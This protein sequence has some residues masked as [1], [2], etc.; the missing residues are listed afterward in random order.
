MLTTKKNTQPSFHTGG[1]S[2]PVLLT[3]IFPD[4]PKGLA[5]SF[6]LRVIYLFLAASGLCCW[7]WAFCSCCGCGGAT[8]DCSVQDS[9]YGSVLVS[10]HRL[11]GW[12]Q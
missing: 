8:L 3:V 7:V 9:H 1:K 4:L 10:D 12:A 6:F 5:F 2:G 11:Q